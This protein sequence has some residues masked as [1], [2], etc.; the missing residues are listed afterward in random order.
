MN[1]IYIHQIE[2]YNTL[3]LSV[4]LQE[5]FAVVAAGFSDPVVQTPYQAVMRLDSTAPEAGVPVAG[6][7]VVAGSF[8]GLPYVPGFAKAGA[9]VNCALHAPSD[10]LYVA[11]YSEAPPVYHIVDIQGSI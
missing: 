11:T 1:K 9:T 7:G 3:A 10:V 5:P 2:G 8:D 6:P 4:T